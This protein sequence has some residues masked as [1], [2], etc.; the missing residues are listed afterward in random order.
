MTAGVPPTPPCAARAQRHSRVLRHGNRGATAPWDGRRPRPAATPAG[1]ERR[2]DRT[3]RAGRRHA[4][5]GVGPGFRADRPN[6]PTGRPAEPCGSK[7]GTAGS[8][9]PSTGH[10]YGGIALAHPGARRS[11]GRHG[12]WRPAA[13]GPDFPDPGLRP[14]R[15]DHPAGRGTRRQCPLA[16]RPPPGPAQPRPARHPGAAG[17]PPRQPGRLRHRQ[18][19]PRWPPFPRAAA[20]PCASSA[21]RCPAARRPLPPPRRHR[22]RPSRRP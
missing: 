3:E 18:A 5:D 11:D 15:D 12:Q 7:H 13:V 4:P 16:P 8:G 19:R 22:E 14:V 6:A 1:P 2:R 17:R 21:S 20:S 9:R 10:E